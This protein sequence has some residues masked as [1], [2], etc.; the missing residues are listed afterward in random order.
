MRR[1]GRGTLFLVG[2]A[3][4]LAA[5]LGLTAYNLWDE[6]RAAAAAGEAMDTLRAEIE[7]VARYTP[8]DLPEETR[9]PDYILDPDMELPTVE[10]DGKLYVGYVDIP[11]L[12]LSLPVLSSWSYPNLKLSPCRYTGTPYQKNM[13]IAA[14]NYPHHF[15]RLKELTAGDEVRFT[16]VDGNVFTYAVAELEQL[17]PRP[18]SAMLDGEWDLTLFTCTLGGQYRVTVRCV[19]ET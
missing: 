19:Q 2:G 8:A 7:P 17:N 11:V 6:N 12:E 18:A 5:S 10:L 16:D 13:V 3:L 9:I 4:L 15:G 1:K 14:H